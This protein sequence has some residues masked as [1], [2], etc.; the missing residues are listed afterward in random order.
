MTI[1]F[2]LERET[3][4]QYGLAP[5]VAV[6]SGGGRRKKDDS[7]VLALLKGKLKCVPFLSPRESIVRISKYRV[8]NIDPDILK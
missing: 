8:H 2:V 6:I 3:G 1:L 5:I 4:Y 7:A